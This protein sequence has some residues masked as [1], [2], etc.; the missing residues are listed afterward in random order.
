MSPAPNFFGGPARGATTSAISSL[1]PATAPRGCPRS[2]E[3]TTRALPS[4]PPAGAA[5]RPSARSGVRSRRVRPRWRVPSARVVRPRWRETSARVVRP[6][7]RVT[8]QRVVRP[9]WRVTSQRVVRPRWRVTSQRVV[10][11]RWRWTSRR[12]LPPCWGV[13]Q[14]PAV[15]P[16]AVE[17]WSPQGRS[18]PLQPSRDRRR[19]PGPVP[20]TDDGMPIRR[21]KRRNS[22]LSVPFRWHNQPR[23]PIPGAAMSPRSSHRCG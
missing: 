5:K 7:W 10:R 9:R 6:R 4:R 22:P 23:L 14:A 12:A 17:L 1:P 13:P 20:A 19:R 11:P 15:H 3:F 2:L 16:P 8:S 18:E 21:R